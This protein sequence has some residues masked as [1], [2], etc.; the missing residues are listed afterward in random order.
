MYRQIGSYQPI[1]ELHSHGPPVTIKK[2]GLRLIIYFAIYNY[3][4]Y[5]STVRYDHLAMALP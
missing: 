1:G 4:H 5:S 2:S 3:S